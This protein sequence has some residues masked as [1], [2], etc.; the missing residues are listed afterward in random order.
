MQDEDQELKIAALIDALEAEHARVRA[1][2][3]A[4][5]ATSARLQQSVAQAAR[6][7]MQEALQGL[8]GELERAQ[9]VVVDL[10]RLSLWRAAWQH[11]MVALIAIV[12]TLVVVSWYVPSGSDMQALRT[13][14][15][16]LEASI[17]DLEQRGGKLQIGHC[18][19]EHRLCVAVDD[20]AGIYGKA[21]DYRIAKGY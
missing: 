2:M 16:Q 18:G 3:E 13:E 10:Q 1:A 15:G 6:L 11:A 9:R 17:A 5:N 12:V 14:K 19:P 20:Y 21:G 4:L 8:H 7:S